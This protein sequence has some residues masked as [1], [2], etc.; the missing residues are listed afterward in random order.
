MQVSSAVRSLRGRCACRAPCP[1]GDALTSECIC[2]TAP[3]ATVRT[4][5]LCM[6]STCLLYTSDAADDM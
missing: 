3:V 2:G 4:R 1:D 6:C 5:G